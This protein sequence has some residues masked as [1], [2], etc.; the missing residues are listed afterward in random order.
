M[1]ACAAQRG[2]LYFLCLCV[3]VCVCASV[4]SV[5]LSAVFLSSRVDVD[6][7]VRIV[8]VLSS[9]PVKWQKRLPLADK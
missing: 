2:L 6:L 1:C 3:C 9:R 4:R 8:C 7:L 5:C